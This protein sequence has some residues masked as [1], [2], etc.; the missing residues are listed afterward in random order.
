MPLLSNITWNYLKSGCRESALMTRHSIDIKRGDIEWNLEKQKNILCKQNYLNIS[1]SKN[2][3]SLIESHNFNFMSSAF[4]PQ[5]YIFTNLEKYQ[6]KCSPDLC[7]LTEG[8]GSLIRDRKGVVNGRQGSNLSLS[9]FRADVYNNGM[10]PKHIN[11]TFK[12][13][14]PYF[15][16]I[17]NGSQ[18][19]HGY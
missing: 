13:I 3:S 18:A 10:V 5:K 15:I 12:F 16:L 6:L 2:C 17:S 8:K 7:D 19:L 4:F 1:S 14:Y 9:G 11:E